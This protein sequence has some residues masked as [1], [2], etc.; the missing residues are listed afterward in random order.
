[1]ARL[2]ELGV[3]ERRACAH[4][5]LSRSVLR[6]KSACDAKNNELQERIREL[7]RE[8]P[9]YGYKRVAALLRRE[10][11]KVNRKRVHRLWK[12]M[13]LQV[14]RKKKKPDRERAERAPKGGTA[15]SR[16]DVGFYL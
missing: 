4:V 11:R 14:P 15:E 12:Q 8:N 16:M 13:K 9:R 7:A 5:R 2:K 10:G 1:M 3:T 6:Y